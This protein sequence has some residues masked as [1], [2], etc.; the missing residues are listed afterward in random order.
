MIIFEST[1]PNDFR[2]AEIGQILNYVLTGKFC[3]VV[4]VP[5]GGKATI[6]RVL[7][8]NR[9]LLKFHLKEKEKSLRLEYINLHGIASFDELQIYKFLLVSLSGEAPVADDPL[10]VARQLREYVNSQAGQKQTLVL[11]LDHFDEYQ[12]QLTRSFFLLLKDMSSVAKYRFSTV[13]ASRR[14]LRELVDPE[15]LKEF[16]DFFTDNAVYVKVYEEKTTNFM[17]SQLEEVFD[18]KLPEKIKLEI[19][20][21]TGGHAKLTKVVGEL[22]LREN[23]EPKIQMLLANPLVSAALFEIWLYLT[24]QEQQVLIQL[25][26]KALL[27]A[28]QIPQNL[29]KSGL[30]AENGDFTIAL[31]EHFIKT[32]VPTIAPVQITYNETTREIKKGEN[33]VSDLLSPQEYRLLRFLIENQGKIAGRDEIIGTVWP[34]A[35]VAEGISD[36]A[37]DQMIFRLRKKIEDQPNVPKH[38]TTIKGQGWRFSP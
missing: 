31:F 12:N 19:V 30:V 27:T 32:T 28:D 16:Y 2:E 22:A 10:L 1:F 9:N 8:H 33:I 21:A 38:I 13:F 26:A 5:G 7:A 35:K 18:K 3:Q 34:D 14:D 36:E 29:I 23:L 20:G 17:L 37:I 11:L 4:S 6:L 15:I 24:A 25:A